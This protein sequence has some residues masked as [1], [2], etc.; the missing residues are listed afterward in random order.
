MTNI[1]KLIIKSLIQFCHL[2]T[3]NKIK[4]HLLYCQGFLPGGA[5]KNQTTVVSAL[6]NQGVKHLVNISYSLCFKLLHLFP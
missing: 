3:P 5:H 1:Y 6:S 4:L 2:E